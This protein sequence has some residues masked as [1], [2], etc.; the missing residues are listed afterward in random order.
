MVN[1]AAT[2][3]ISYPSAPSLGTW[4]VTSG[5]YF[6]PTAQRSSLRASLAFEGYGLQVPGSA[7]NEKAPVDKGDLG[8]QT[9]H[10][11]RPRRGVLVGMGPAALPSEAEEDR[12][13]WSVLCM[14]TVYILYLGTIDVHDT[15]E[16]LVGIG[17]AKAVPA[18]TL[19]LALLMEEDQMKLSR[20]KYAELV[21]FYKQT[22]SNSKA[23]LRV[24]M[25]A[26]QQ[27][28]SIYSRHE[29]YVLEALRRKDRAE[30][31]AESVRQQDGA[32]ERQDSPEEMSLRLRQEE[33]AEVQRTRAMFTFPK[34]SNKASNV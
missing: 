34:P 16:Y 28:N 4:T 29:F 10:W 13:G 17:P 8:C 1:N 31:R 15:D 5:D 14:R 25:S 21:R 22:V 7:G 27:L 30:S 24:R 33:A 18:R 26:A 32:L 12:I 9:V 11:P 19:S 20:R 2:D 23:S 6:S 3:R